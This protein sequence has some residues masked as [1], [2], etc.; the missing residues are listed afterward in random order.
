M[1]NVCAFDC[2]GS[3]QQCDGED[4]VDVHHEMSIPQATFSSLSRMWPDRRLPVALRL[5]L[6]CLAVCSTFSHACGAWDLAAA[7]IGNIGGFNSGCLH[8]ITGKSYRE[9][10]VNP[11]FNLV[12]AIR[13]RRLRY[14]GHNLRL[15]PERLLRKALF[16]YVMGSDAVPAGSLTADCPQDLSLEDLARL[17]T[18]R[19]RWADMVNNTR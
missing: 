5:H 12:R 14:L 17:A 3:Q 11:D 18:D 16:A 4:G 2:L 1:E 8:V 6:C 10:A 9:T 7:V 19:K 13:Q 15:P